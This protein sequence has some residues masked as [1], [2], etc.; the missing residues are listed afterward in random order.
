MKTEGL[1]VKVTGGG[2]GAG[3]GFKAVIEKKIGGGNGLEGREAFGFF[4]GME[5]GCFFPEM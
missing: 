3:S 5:N 2:V 1:S 4:A